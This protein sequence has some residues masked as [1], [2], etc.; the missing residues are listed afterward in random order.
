MGLYVLVLL[1]F[2]PLFVVAGLKIVQ[3]AETVVIERWAGIT[4]LLK[5]GINFRAAG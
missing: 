1:V 5:S 4:R 3:Q 2:S